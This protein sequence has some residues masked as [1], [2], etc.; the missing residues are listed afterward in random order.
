MAFL[1]RVGS[2][3]L[4]SN[5]H[6]YRRNDVYAYQ[7]VGSTA[8]QPICRV[9]P[10]CVDERSH[11]GD[12]SWVAAISA[13]WLRANPLPQGD[14]PRKVSKG[15]DMRSLRVARPYANDTRVAVTVP[16]TTGDYGGPVRLY[17]YT[18]EEALDK[19]FSGSYCAY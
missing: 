19:R 15:Q 5:Y 9:V 3:F 16:N 2:V 11:C 1:D 7:I 13:G 10:I 18:L 12:G 6:S 14:P 8:K 4:G 17:L